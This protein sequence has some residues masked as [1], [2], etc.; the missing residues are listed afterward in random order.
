[1]R[2]ELGHSC[3]DLDRVCTR[4]RR[5]LWVTVEALDELGTLSVCQPCGCFFSALHAPPK[6]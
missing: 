4:C 6:P 3:P 1:V 2:L 5:P